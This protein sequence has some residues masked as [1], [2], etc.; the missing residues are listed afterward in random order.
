MSFMAWLMSSSK[1]Q[2]PCFF[3]AIQDSFF[4]ITPFMAACINEIGS[5]LPPMDGIC[6]LGRDVGLLSQVSDIFPEI[7]FSLAITLLQG[8][9]MK[10]SIDSS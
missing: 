7:C 9:C 4:Y 6:V 5:Y 8:F 3:V 10:V 1:H 2:S